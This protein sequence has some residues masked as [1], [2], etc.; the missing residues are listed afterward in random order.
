M[1]QSADVLDPIADF[2]S[3]IPAGGAGTRLWPLSRAGRPKFLHDL[4]GQGRSLL[5]ATADRL[6][7]LSQD[8]L[9]V[10][11]GVA[12]EAA[13]R[14]QLGEFGPQV[15]AEPSPRDS[16]AAIGLAAA[17][18]ERRDP[19]AVIGSFAAD[20]VVGDEAAFRSCVREAIEVARTGMLVTLGIAPT[21]PATGFGYIHVGAPL[22]VAGAPHAHRV[23]SFVEKP[24]AATATAYVEGGEFV[25]NA[26][27]FVATAGG[28]LDLLARYHPDLAQG[29]RD[30]AAAPDRLE[31]LWPTLQRISI[32][33]A[34]AEPAAD[35]GH[36]AVVQTEFPWDDVGDFRSLAG[37]LPEAGED[38]P[39]GLRVLG[40][41]G[42]V[43][44]ADASGLVAPCGRRLIAV[45]GLEDVVVVDTGDAVLVT[46][47]AR[48]QDVKKI[49]DELKATGRA[50]LT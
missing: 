41:P 5:Q 46:T 38:L 42:A 35:D 7:P 48:A 47:S 1:A 34:V 2:W 3:V 37:L 15:L 13:V 21:Y 44:A 24:D 10:V 27:M 39:A 6:R 29:L 14:R 49:V 31:A 16:M 45:V 28:L 36:V 9:V 18:V 11:T 19:Q 17:V 32:D 43:I 12:H 26:G 40:D 20:H 4:T 25:W 50:E 23:A 30:I 33:H 22:D 8:R